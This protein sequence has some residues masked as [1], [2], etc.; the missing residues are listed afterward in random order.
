MIELKQ[1]NKQL[2]QKNVINNMSFTLENGHILGL[3][4]SNGA[5]K[6]T[7]LRLLSGI[8]QLDSGELTIDSEKVYDN[9]SIK[10]TIF[11]IN[12]ETVQ[13]NNYTILDL[14]NYYKAYYTNFSEELFA[15]LIDITALPTDQKMNRFSKGMKR[16]AILAVGLSC[17][18][19]YL[20]LDEAFDGIDQTMRLTVKR[21]LIDA[22]LDRNL[23]VIISSHHLYELNEICDTI[24]LMH[25]GNILSIHELDE[26]RNGMFKIEITTD[27]IKTEADF[28]DLALLHFSQRGSS[29]TMVARGNSEDLKEICN[30]KNITIDSMEPLTL[31]EIFVYEMEALGY[32]SKQI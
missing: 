21:I 4:G 22:V 8:Y 11:F 25:K 29:I 27:E 3:I 6:S 26:L 19:K 16:Q 20:F 7:L 28:N 13:F 10:E 18:T 9:V 23:T 31:D 5:G 2:N 17:M 30:H 1:V 14:K 24:A 15:R 32:D 12:D